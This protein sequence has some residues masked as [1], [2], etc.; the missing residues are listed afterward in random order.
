MSRQFRHGT[1]RARSVEAG[2][3][4]AAIVLLCLSERMC[5]PAHS[6]LECGVKLFQA[7]SQYARENRYLLTILA[8]H[9]SF[10][11]KI[12]SR[13]LLVPSMLKKWLK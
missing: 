1:A 3:R 7:F 10:K 6:N 5:F 8:L 12:V 11:A 13:Y 4:E 9:Q 2:T